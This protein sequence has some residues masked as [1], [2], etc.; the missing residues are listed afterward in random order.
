MPS[1]RSRD[2]SPTHRS[3]PLALTSATVTP[4]TPAAPPLRRTIRHASKR[5]SSLHTLSASAWNRKS[6]S[7][8]AFACSTVWSF[9][10]LTA[11]PLRLSSVAK[12]LP[13]FRTARNSG[14]LPST[15]V[16]RRPQYYGPI[17]HPAGPVC[18]SRGPGCRV[19]GTDRASRV[20]ALPISHTCRR[21]YPGGNQPVLVS[22]TSRPASG[23]PLT[24]GGSAPALPVSR[25]AQRSFAFRPAWSLNPL[26]T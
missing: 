6:G 13:P 17:R 21:Q 3:A 19:H 18:P 24:V 14:P 22:F 11:D 12:S 26:P 1:L 9:R 10:T 20:A 15:G 23:L 7:P 16:T 2:S 5:K 8:F 25:P 4:S